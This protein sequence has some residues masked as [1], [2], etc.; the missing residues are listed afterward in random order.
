VLKNKERKLKPKR[1]RKIFF[2]KLEMNELEIS[3]K[4]KGIK[5]ERKKGGSVKNILGVSF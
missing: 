4:K 5:K 1:G 2:L 3:G